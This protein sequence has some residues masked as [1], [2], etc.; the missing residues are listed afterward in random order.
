MR[1][2]LVI[3][4]L[5]AMFMLPHVAKAQEP[6]VLLCMADCSD[7]AASGNHH[8]IAPGENLL[9]ILRQ[10]RYGSTGLQT[11]IEKVVH[12]NPRAFLRGDPDRMVAG[13]TLIL[14]EADGFPTVPDH[15][16]LF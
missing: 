11:V 6:W 7:T 13:Q 12:D 10:Y 8:I 3:L 16:Y 1:L 4:P 14:P 5:L 15:I 2:G 9:G